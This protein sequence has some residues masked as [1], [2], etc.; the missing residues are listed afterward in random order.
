M[1]NRHQ[2]SRRGERATLLDR[3]PLH[4]PSPKQK[5]GSALPL[6]AQFDSRLHER[7]YKSHVAGSPHTTLLMALAAGIGIPS[8]KRAVQGLGS[9]GLAP[10]SNK[11]PGDL[12]EGADGSGSCAAT[13]QLRRVPPSD[14]SVSGCLDFGAEPAAFPMGQ[15]THSRET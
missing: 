8:S 7:V 4:A 2:T 10:A 3:A 13:S 9:S 1:S 15:S 14:R 6:Q 12:P 11:L 5:V